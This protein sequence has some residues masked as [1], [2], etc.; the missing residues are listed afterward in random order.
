MFPSLPDQFSEPQGK[1]MSLYLFI[2]YLLVC[3]QNAFYTVECRIF[4]VWLPGKCKVGNLKRVRR[5]DNLLEVGPMIKRNVI[6]YNDQRNEHFPN[7]LQKMK[8]TKSDQP[9]SIY[10]NRILNYSSIM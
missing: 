9:E 7:L 4:I 3:N 2:N 10:Y 5:E 6:T 1:N 8:A